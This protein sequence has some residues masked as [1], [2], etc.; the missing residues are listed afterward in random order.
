MRSYIDWDVTNYE[1]KI[2]ILT[3][4]ES[5]EFFRFPAEGGGVSGHHYLRAYK[6]GYFKLLRQAVLVGRTPRTATWI[7]DKAEEYWK[8]SQDKVRRHIW[9]RRIAWDRKA[10]ADGVTVAAGDLPS[11]DPNSKAV[12]TSVVRDTIPRVS[13][14]KWICDY[15]YL[16]REWA[17]ATEAVKAKAPGYVPADDAAMNGAG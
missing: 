4:L 16:V 2:E 10:L 11:L 3:K 9:L 14:Q 5:E 1:K 8:A 13:C 12:G 6:S 15:I 17:E 7:L